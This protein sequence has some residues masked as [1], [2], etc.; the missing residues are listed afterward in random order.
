MK[1]AFT[2]I[3]CCALACFFFFNF[4]PY[5]GMSQNQNNQVSTLALH[6]APITQF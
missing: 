2:K 1:K 6:E 3:M 5:F 4:M